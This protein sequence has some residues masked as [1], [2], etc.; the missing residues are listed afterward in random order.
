MINLPEATPVYEA[1]RLEDDL[2]R[3]GIAAKWWVVNQSLYGTNTSNPILTAKAAGEI[4]WLNRINEHSNGKFAL[5][6]WSPED[7]KGD[8]LLTL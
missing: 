1:L 3:A 4:E 5:I 7:I 2:N 6:S 8:R